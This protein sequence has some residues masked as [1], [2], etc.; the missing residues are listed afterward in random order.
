MSKLASVYRA[1]GPDASRVQTVYISVDTKRDTPAVLKEYLTNFKSVH[2]IGLTGTV[3]EIDTVTNLFGAQY[4]IAPVL[5]TS[6][7]EQTYTVAHTTS[8]YALDP[9]GRTRLIFPYEATVAEM[10]KGVRDILDSERT[11]ATPG[12]ELP[13]FASMT[14]APAIPSANSENRSVELGRRRALP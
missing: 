11:S 5:D 10:T 8:V 14:E 2:A 9:E 6:T 1:L 4:Q 3:P 12:V 13:E 7:S